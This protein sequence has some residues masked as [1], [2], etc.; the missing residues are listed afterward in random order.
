MDSA[1]TRGRGS[2]SRLRGVWSNGTTDFRFSIRYKAQRQAGA[3][4]GFQHGIRGS[5]GLSS[6]R[7]LQLLPALLQPA[8][9]PPL[10]PPPLPPAAAVGF[11][12]PLLRIRGGIRVGHLLVLA[13]QG[14]QLGP[15][16]GAVSLLICHSTERHTVS[17]LPCFTAR[18]RARALESGWLSP[19]AWRLV[20][21]ESHLRP[22]RPLRRLHSAPE[23]GPPATAAA[24]TAM[25]DAPRRRAARR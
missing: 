22:R 12:C 13:V 4:G 10:P 19:V 14:P 23:T 16:L 1:G 18:L 6:R 7:E 17:Q 3:A 2:G 24:H 5:A 21:S 25:R 8:I 11:D 9:T 20:R 15:D